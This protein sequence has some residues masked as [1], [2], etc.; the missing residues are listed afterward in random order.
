M[1]VYLSG[2]M[3]WAMLVVR[4]VREILVNFGG[5]GNEVVYNCSEMDTWV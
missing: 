3:S 4:G 2:Q 5:L 1:C